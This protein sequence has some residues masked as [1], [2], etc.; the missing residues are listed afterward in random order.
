M[1]GNEWLRLEFFAV[2]WKFKKGWGKKYEWN[3]RSRR[4]LKAGLTLNNLKLKRPVSTAGQGE[5]ER[6]QRAGKSKG[7]RG[8]N[9]VYFIYEMG[10]HHLT[11]KW[12][13]EY[14]I[15]F[16]SLIYFPFRFFPSSFF[17]PLPFSHFIF[18]SF[19][20]CKFTWINFHLVF[21]LISLSIIWLFTIIMAMGWLAGWGICILKFT[22]WE[23]IK[24]CQ[25]QQ[26]QLSIIL[27]LSSTAASALPLLCP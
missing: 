27:I 6:R 14:C 3:S 10:N 17:L 18:H 9:C 12:K 15:N 26:Q 25:Q 4:G 11:R 20:I 1:N 8:A 24:L 19:F 7:W 5:R 16:Y 22:E 23:F 2:E 21:A 13:F